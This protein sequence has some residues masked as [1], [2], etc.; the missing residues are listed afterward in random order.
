MHLFEGK[1]RNMFVCAQPERF[2]HQRVIEGTFSSRKERLQ[3][4]NDDGYDIFF[5][6]NKLASK[7]GRFLPR[8]KE[9]IS[10]IR[11]I[12]QEDDNDWQGGFPLPPHYV[13]QTSP[14]HFHRY[15]IIQ[16]FVDMK[17]AEALMEAMVGRF[18]SDP[19][20]KDITRLLRVPGFRNHKRGGCLVH[21]V[22]DNYQE[23]YTLRYI[24]ELFAGVKAQAMF[25]VEQ[26]PATLTPTRV[27][28]HK[29]NNA[30]DFLD[31]LRSGE[32]LH[33]PI[34]GLMMMM[35]NKGHDAAFI[36]ATLEGLMQSVYPSEA[37]RTDPEKFKKQ[38]RDLPAMIKTT[39]GKVQSETQHIEL[40]L[41][42]L[43]APINSMEGIPLPPGRAGRLV[44]YT[45]K[46]MRYPNEAMA[47]ATYFAFMSSF[48]AR[49]FNISDSGLNTYQIIFAD[50]G[51]GKSQIN[52]GFLELTRLTLG[53]SVRLP[54]DYLGADGFTSVKA[55]VNEVKLRPCYLAVID[56]F[57]KYLHSK[58]GDPDSVMKFF[59]SNY[60]ES[61]E[62][63]VQKGKAY[64]DPNNSNETI[65][66][67]A[68][69]LI[70]MTNE[71]VSTNNL[72]LDAH[73]GFVPRCLVY[74]LRDLPRKFQVP[75]QRHDEK[76]FF[77]S[78]DLSTLANLRHLCDKINELDEPN[79]SDFIHIP[80]PDSINA[81]YERERNELYNQ[82]R[83]E[84]QDKALAGIIVRQPHKLMRLAAIIAVTNADSY[85][86][87]R[88]TDEILDWAKM[89]ISRE[90][91]C[92]QPLLS[93]AQGLS[94]KSDA[95]R[96][97][98][99]KLYGWFVNTKHYSTGALRN[100]HPE[101]RKQLLFNTTILKR[102]VQK[103]RALMKIAQT[104]KY[105]SHSIEEEV[106]TFWKSKR[107]VKDV[108]A[109]YVG[110]IIKNT[111]SEVLQFD[112]D[113]FMAE[114]GKTYE[115]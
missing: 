85:H 97:C 115:L 38:A 49:K 93:V 29:K 31:M 27:N 28:G 110:D 84:Q 106:L 58:S 36:T 104:N 40:E 69:S 59:L 13:V 22:E 25:H 47:I 74:N 48:V 86:D 64:S 39:L 75:I 20:A 81:E 88:I 62:S 11:A 95:R 7:N 112:K 2:Q 45:L 33:T 44:E 55:L 111:K 70:G 12:W 18:G 17:V 19:G 82:I 56:E 109:H 71:D 32:H 9:N 52:K 114:L 37:V 23:P 90:F 26:G 77:H 68:F 3:A 108:T 100:F 99:E 34:R 91:Q 72:L 8:K 42:D 60:T 41:L 21:L 92:F 101:H 67:V 35:A 83:L 73:D 24:T 6:V 105:N 43:S 4:L 89:F 54:A 113:A 80:V 79:A 16:D 65:H 107:M 96:I 57:G 102:L 30:N 66:S 51:F 10:A 14:G 78:D 87:I 1:H 98:A 94:S 103:N 50:T 15:W 53:D 76:P 46:R 5:V 61:G 63:S